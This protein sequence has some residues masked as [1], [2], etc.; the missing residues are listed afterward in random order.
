ML[1]NVILCSPCNR[2]THDDSF[3]SDDVGDATI[4][5]SSEIVIAV[6]SDPCSVDPWGATIFRNVLTARRILNI[7]PDRMIQFILPWVIQHLCIRARSLL[8]ASSRFVFNSP[9]QKPESICFLEDA[10]RRLKDVLKDVH[11]YCTES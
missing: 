11:P 6:L 4:L 10:E 2:T 3:T 7:S 5:R 9:S 1:F 8:S